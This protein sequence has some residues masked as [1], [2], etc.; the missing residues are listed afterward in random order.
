MKKNY[1]AFYQTYIQDQKGYF[2][3]EKINL[4]INQGEI[5]CLTGLSN[6]GEAAILQYLSGNAKRI[7][8][9]ISINGK[10]VNQKYISEEVKKDF[11]LSSM[12]EMEN[13]DLN[14]MEYLMILSCEHFC[15][16]LW[17]E[18]ENKKRAEQLLHESGMNMEVTSKCW[19]LRP[20]EK[21][22]LY[23]LRAGYS[24]AKMIMIHDEYEDISE[25]E[26]ERY[27]EIIRRMK[28]RGFSFIIMT[29]NVRFAAKF[30]DVT[31]IFK[32]YHII[33]KFYRNQETQESIS[34]YITRSVGV[35]KKSNEYERK[36]KYRAEIILHGVKE[37][38]RFS[39]NTG[40][41]LLIKTEDTRSLMK[42]F[43]VLCGKSSGLANVFFRG[44]KLSPTTLGNQYKNKIIFIRSFSDPKEVF[45]NISIGEN[46]ILPNVKKIH[47]FHFRRIESAEKAM[48]KQLGSEGELLTEAGR[49]KIILERWKIFAP[50]LVVLKTPFLN[51]D[52][53]CRQNINKWMQELVQEGTSFIILTSEIYDYKKIYHRIWEFKDERNYG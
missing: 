4:L 25:D 14:L 29:K 22:I 44:K 6:A 11:Y 2:C 3:L 39:V 21:R 37:R 15:P 19:N 50:E 27:D 48:A 20:V 7:K 9:K 1:V 32:D 52:Y 18:K 42:L 23:L 49:L 26:L 28:E 53:D 34:S 10:D 51:L 43:S 31:C 12:E 16:Q 38:Q 45:R 41:I 46:L 13:K 35:L 33:K 17:N 24:G 40:E 5:V 36:E 47:P 8:G 30:A